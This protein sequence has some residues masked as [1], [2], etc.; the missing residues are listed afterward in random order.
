MC[1]R[2]QMDEAMFQAARRYQ[3]LLEESGRAGAVK[4]VDV[5]APVISGSQRAEESPARTAK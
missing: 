4:S 3:R 2:G 1:A 5:S